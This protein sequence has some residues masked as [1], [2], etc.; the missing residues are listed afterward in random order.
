[1]DLL[2]GLFIHTRSQ[3]VLVHFHALIIRILSESVPHGT[4]ATALISLAE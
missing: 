4:D 3:G 1:M 2:L